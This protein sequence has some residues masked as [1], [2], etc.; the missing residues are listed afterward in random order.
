[1]LIGSRSLSWNDTRLA[2]A[3]FALAALTLALQGATPLLARAFYAL[4]N[5]LL[6][7]LISTAAM[8]ADIAVIFLL[9]PWL[10]S[11]SGASSAWLWLNLFGVDDVRVLALTA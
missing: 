4:K 8:A 9:K 3:T 1:I 5:T 10:S 11:G 7:V 6:P 2:A